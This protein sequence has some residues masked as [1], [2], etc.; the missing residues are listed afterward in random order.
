MNHPRVFLIWVNRLVSEA[1]DVLLKREG[2]APLGMECDPDLALDRVRAL[3]PDVVL[4]EGDSE[5]KDARLFS[6]LAQLVYERE[7]LRVI[8]L[9]L[10]DGQL[11]I[12]HQEQRRL[13]STQDL[14]AAIRAFDEPR[15]PQTA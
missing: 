11:H 7:N 15:D 10:D 3:N 6:K 5:A 4:V 8:R 1:V 13:I 14:V 2:I 9:C 12:Y